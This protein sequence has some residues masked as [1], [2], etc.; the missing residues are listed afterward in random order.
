MLTHKPRRFVSGG[1]RMCPPH[2]WV[3]GGQESSWG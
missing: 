3:S 1:A 2:Q